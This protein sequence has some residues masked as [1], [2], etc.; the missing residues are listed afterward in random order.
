MVLMTNTLQIT[1]YF[2]YIPSQILST[3]KNHSEGNGDIY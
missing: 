1:I 2:F 3:I